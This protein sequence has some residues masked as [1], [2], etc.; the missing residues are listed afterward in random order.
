[1]TR[2]FIPE[3]E[4]GVNHAPEPWT[5]PYPHSKLV[6][7]RDGGRVADTYRGTDDDPAASANAARIVAC[8]N[9][10]AGVPDDQLQH[11][12]PFMDAFG[13]ILIEAQRAFSEPRG[14]YVPVLEKQSHD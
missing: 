7:D 12:K 9:A 4:L 8:V 5:Q 11:V 3:A 2:E 14:F 1:M 10:L 6:R 13:D